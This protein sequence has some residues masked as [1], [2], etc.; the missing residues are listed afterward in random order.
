[1]TL[2]QRKISDSCEVVAVS[3]AFPAVACTFNSFC[4]E[5]SSAVYPAMSMLELAKG[6]SLEE[7]HGSLL[8]GLQKLPFLHDFAKQLMLL[9]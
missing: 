4:K 7:E 2:V 1:M 6:L 8:E 9:A 3:G 5:S